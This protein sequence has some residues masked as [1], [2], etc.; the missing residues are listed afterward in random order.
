M[1]YVEFTKDTPNGHKKGD[2]VRYPEFA[3]RSLVFRGVAAYVAAPRAKKPAPEPAPQADPIS[4]LEGMTKAELL[5]EAEA[6]GVALPYKAT[7]AEI[8]GILNGGE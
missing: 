2:V 8:L 4:S 3:A 6:R 1:V 7:K 5:Q